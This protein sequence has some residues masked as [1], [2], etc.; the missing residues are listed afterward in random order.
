[1]NAC[2]VVRSSRPAGLFSFGL[3]D[4]LRVRLRRP[5]LREVTAGFGLERLATAFMNNRGSCPFDRFIQRRAAF[6]DVPRCALP[7]CRP[8]WEESRLSSIARPSRARGPEGVCADRF[9][10]VRR[11]RSSRSPVVRCYHEQPGIIRNTFKNERCISSV[12][13]LV[14]R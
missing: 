4:G 5:R 6:P 9:R 2:S 13:R 8:I 1:M 14:K 7:R 3:L 11:S 12:R 10:S